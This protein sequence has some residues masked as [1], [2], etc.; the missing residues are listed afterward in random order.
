MATPARVLA[1]GQE[2]TSSYRGGSD[3]TPLH[4]VSSVWTSFDFDCELGVMWMMNAP[5][6]VGLLRLL[7]LLGLVSPLWR[8]SMERSVPLLEDPDSE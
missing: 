4:G 7:G 3:L 8:A 2:Q 1:V 5:K 6:L